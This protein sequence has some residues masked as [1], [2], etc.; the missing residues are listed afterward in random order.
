MK[1]KGESSKAK[2]GREEVQ[3][4]QI[5]GSTRDVLLTSNTAESKEKR[6]MRKR[7]GDGGKTEKEE[8]CERGETYE[9]FTNPHSKTL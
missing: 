1:R 9:Y 2:A 5:C 4:V 8:D 3:W 7:L 6:K